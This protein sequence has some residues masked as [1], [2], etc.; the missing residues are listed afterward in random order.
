VRTGYGAEGQ[1]RND[2][3]HFSYL[4]SL[5]WEWEWEWQNE[6]NS[7]RTEY[8]TEKREGMEKI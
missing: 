8:Q 7:F 6:D 5:K 3:E 2:A 4:K 1:R